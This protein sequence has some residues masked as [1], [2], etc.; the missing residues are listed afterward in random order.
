MRSA[1]GATL[2]LQSESIKVLIDHQVAERT[3]AMCLQ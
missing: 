3:V 1:R 2:P